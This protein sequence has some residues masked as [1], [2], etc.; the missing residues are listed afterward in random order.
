MRELQRHAFA[1]IHVQRFAVNVREVSPRGKEQNDAV[2]CQ[3]HSWQSGRGV[4]KGITGIYDPVYSTSAS[5]TLT[6]I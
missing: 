4:L 5:V 3:T 6:K 2:C 1:A